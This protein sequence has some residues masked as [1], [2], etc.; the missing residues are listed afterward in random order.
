MTL[1]LCVWLAMAGSPVVLEVA[2]ASTKKV[3]VNFD[4][5]PL[6]KVIKWMS[7]NTGKNFIVKDDLRNHPVTIVSGSKVTVEEAYQAFL[8]ALETEG[9][10]M[11]DAGK[12]KKIVRRSPGYRRH[13][14][15]LSPSEPRDSCG[16][17]TGVSQV[18]D[19]TWI[20]QRDEFDKQMANLNCVAT[21]ARMVPAIK[22]G[23]PRGF[24]LYAIKPES[25]YAKI[26]FNNGDLITKINGQDISTPDKA[27]EVYGILK[28]AETI[29]I[30]IERRKKIR[31]HTYLIK[32]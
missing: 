1:I 3:L 10:E 16:P 26:G 12:F 13:R 32:K 7:K 30:E 22:D 20:I 8:Q 6:I 24:K 5:Q 31:I 18:D 25:L 4:S 29:E 17:V 19:R 15:P 9:F 21:K 14:D 11:I 23:K 27:L 28:S 2:Q